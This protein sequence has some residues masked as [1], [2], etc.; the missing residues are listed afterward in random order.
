MNILM[1][2][3]DN[4]FPPDI[5]VKK[6]T[7]ALIAVGHKIALIARRGDNQTKKELLNGVNVYRIDYP[8]WTSIR[9]IRGFLYFV[10][11]RYLV[12]FHILFLSKKFNVDALHV[13]DLP[14]A[15]ATCLAGKIV[16]KP[17][18]YDMHEDYVEVMSYDIKDLSRG[19][20]LL[21][22]I[23]LKA[24]EIEEKLACKLSSRI[25]VVVEEEVNRLASMSVPLEKIEVIPN[26]ASI[27]TLNDIKSK[28]T[29]NNKYDD[30]FKICYVGGFSKHRGLDTLVKAIPQILRDI[31]NAHLL[32]VGDGI[33]KEEL[34]RLCEVLHIREY[35]TLT[36]WIS[37]EEAMGFIEKSDVC[38]LPYHSTRQTN[39]SFPHKLG[40]YMYFE[41]PILASNVKS[42]KRII[43]ENECGII[44]RAGDP[45]D[46]ARKLIEAK[47]TGILKQL[48]LNGRKA[49]ETRYNWKET[50]K[51]L[52]KLYDELLS[53]AF[54][55]H[56][57]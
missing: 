23:Y 22:S 50:S 25:I 32:L 40:Q 6:E 16:G 33:M 27:E 55:K 39:K 12:F 24:L 15:S 42:L 29:T 47:K 38:V 51:R 30:R 8:L 35:V 13:H 53:T 9:L 34:Y 45:E 19:L 2:L 7:E 31:P 28:K 54:S 57:L 21:C 1:V 18:V 14:F 4:T 17:V 26:T 3:S 48:G 41:K 5:R 49:V 46:L 11:Y 44:F 52:V 10:I 56:S 37:F 36:G 20:R 43:E